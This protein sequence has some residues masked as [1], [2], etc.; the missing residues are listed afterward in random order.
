[1]YRAARAIAEPTPA[2]AQAATASAKP[3]A[4]PVS[5]APAAIT[6]I[7]AAAVTRSPNR[8]TIG[9]ATRSKTRRASP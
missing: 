6:T 3:G 1:V 4:M 8:S 5:A 7:P 9:P 2:V